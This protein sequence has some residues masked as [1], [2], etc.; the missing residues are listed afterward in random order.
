MLGLESRSAPHRALSLGG[1]ALCIHFLN[2]RMR[3]VDF[4]LCFGHTKCNLDIALRGKKSFILFI[5]FMEML[6]HLPNFLNAAPLP[7]HLK[8]NEEICVSF[9]VIGP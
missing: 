6:I 3:D 7:H 9:V 5:L 4:R 1:S 8:Y 2:L